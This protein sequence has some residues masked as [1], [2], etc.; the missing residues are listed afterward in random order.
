MHL[1][2]RAPLKHSRHSTIPIARPKPAKAQWPTPNRC[3]GFDLGHPIGA[4][5]LISVKLVRGAR[6][7]DRPP[8]WQ[9]KTRRLAH[10][11]GG[12]S[13]HVYGFVF[14]PF[15]L[16]RGGSQ[17]PPA[18]CPSLQGV[19][20]LNNSPHPSFTPPSPI[21]RQTFSLTLP[22]PLLPPRAPTMA[23]PQR[24]ICPVHTDDTAFPL[25]GS[26]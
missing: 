11:A 24:Y 22:L 2:Q 17:H 15:L 13:N 1:A 4:G 6:G 5:A 19:Q 9:R 8:H 26:L 23:S 18:Q 16:E 7:F 21:R 14:L 12:L 20:A 3:G 25:K 10:A